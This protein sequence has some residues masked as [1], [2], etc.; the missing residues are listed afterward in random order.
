MVWKYN[1]NTALIIVPVLFVDRQTSYCF[2]NIAIILK[3]IIT[4]EE[5]LK[6]PIEQ[7]GSGCLASTF[8]NVK[9]ENKNKNT[10]APEWIRSFSHSGSGSNMTYLQKSY[11]VIQ[12]QKLVQGQGLWLL[13][14]RDEKTCIDES[15]SWFEFYMSIYNF[16][17]F[18]CHQ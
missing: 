14:C 8:L 2:S 16:I 15:I 5:T 6:K 10:T 12:I 1:T 18:N 4:T 13:A 17:I 11:G 7:T 3:I 9:R